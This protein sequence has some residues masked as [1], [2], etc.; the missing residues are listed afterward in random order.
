MK[1]ADISVGLGLK[2]AG[3][4]PRTLRGRFLVPP[5]SVLDARQAYWQ[6]RKRAWLSIGL[7]GEIGRGNQLTYHGGRASLPRGAAPTNENDFTKLALFVW[8]DCFDVPA[9]FF[10]KK[11]ELILTTQSCSQTKNIVLFIK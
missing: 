10:S 5:F 2:T 7:R 4:L 9:P 6:E 8:R 3:G 11:F 1:H